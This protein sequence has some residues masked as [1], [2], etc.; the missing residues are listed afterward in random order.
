M[1]DLT[2]RGLKSSPSQL[3]PFRSLTLSRNCS[4]KEVA[5]QYRILLTTYTTLSN[6]SSSHTTVEPVFREE[7]MDD[8]FTMSELDA[9][10]SSVKPH[11]SPGPDGIRYSYLIHMGKDAQKLLLNIY[12]SSWINEN[13]P[14]SWKEARIVPLL[15]PGKSPLQLTSYRPVALASCIGKIMEKMIHRRLDWYLEQRGIYPEIMQGFRRGRSSIDGVID[16]V[17]C[18][19]QERAHRKITIAA[20]LDIKGAFDNVTRSRSDISSSQR[21]RDW[22]TLIQVDKKLP[23]RK[24]NFY[25]YKRRKHAFLPGDPWCPSGGRSQSY[26]I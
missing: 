11:T 16:L 2:S 18:I 25:V 24:I 15:K 20:F 7:A 19:Q 26:I 23:H 5:N 21:N 14:G 9:A 10:L 12:N 1:E 22:G 3:H 4:E 13:V 17:T 6:Q 8:L